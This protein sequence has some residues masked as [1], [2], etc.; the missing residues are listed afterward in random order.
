MNT[1]FCGIAQGIVAAP[2]RPT[3]PNRT[4]R[5]RR[6][7]PSPPPRSRG[8]ALAPLW[9]LWRRFGGEFVTR[10]YSAWIPNGEEAI[11]CRHRQQNGCGV[12]VS[13]GGH[14]RPELSNSLEVQGGMPVIGLQETEVL[15]GHLSQKRV[16]ARCTYKSLRLPSDFSFCTSSIRKSNL[17]ARE[18]AS[19]CASHDSQSRSESQRANSLN[20]SAVSWVISALSFSIVLIPYPTPACLARQCISAHTCCAYVKFRANHN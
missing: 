1:I 17:P 15:S 16:V 18:S 11:L 9:R 2:E 13:A 14:A 6:P 7:A 12:C 20:S 3:P 5:C 8:S 10:Y 4:R 19:I